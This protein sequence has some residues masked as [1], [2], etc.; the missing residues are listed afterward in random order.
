MVLCKACM[1]PFKTQHTHTH[2]EHKHHHQEKNKKN[3][4]FLFRAVQSQKPL[5]IKKKNNIHFSSFQKQ[6]LNN[7]LVLFSLECSGEAVVI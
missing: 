5:Q 7:G 3:K 2:T 4:C 1:H 6:Q